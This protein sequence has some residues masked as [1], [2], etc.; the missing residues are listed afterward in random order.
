[1]ARSESRTTWAAVALA[2]AITVPYVVIF[3]QTI[4]AILDP[5]SVSEEM[6]AG[7]ASLGAMSEGNQVWIAFSYLA[8]VLGAI[9]LVVLLVIA[10]LIARRQAAREAA[11]AVFG[12]IT[13]IAGLAGLGALVRGHPSGGSWLGAITSLACLGVVVL[14]ALES[15]GIDFELAEMK[16]RR[17]AS[18]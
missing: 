17:R 9:N 3:I 15:T 6:L 4:R 18:Q 11:F 5:D 16:R 12:I 1:M 2:T 10:G 13:L 14:L 8:A 7:L